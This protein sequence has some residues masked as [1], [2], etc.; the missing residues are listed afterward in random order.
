MQ[1]QPPTPKPKTS[2]PVVGGQIVKLRLGSQRHQTAVGSLHSGCPV[3]DEDVLLVAV[4]PFEETLMVE[5]YDVIN[6]GVVSP[7]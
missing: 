4:E 2:P 3:W 1:K 6:F 5:V 7:P